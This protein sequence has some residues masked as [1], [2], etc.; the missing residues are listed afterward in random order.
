[1]SWPLHGTPGAFGGLETSCDYAGARFAV[2]PIP[3]DGTSTWLKG[4]DRG[5]AAM[6][7]ASANME[8]FDIE[9]GTE[10]WRSGILTAA[11]VGDAGDPESTVDAVAAAAGRFLDG[12]K[13]VLGLGGEHSVTAGLVRAHAERIPG[14]SVL[15]FDA[16]CDRRESYEGSPW[17]HACVMARVAEICPCVQ[18]GIRS[19]DVS[20]SA[21]LDSGRIFTASRI[22]GDSSF[23]SDVADLLTDDVYVTVD[24]D[25]LDPG[26]MPSTGTP[27]PGGMDWWQLLSVLRRVSRRR[28][29]VGCDIVELMPRDCDRAPDFLAARLAY[30]VMAYVLTG[31]EST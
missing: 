10:P 12:G 8:L 4:A 26:I 3:Y 25:V 11:P 18:V 27:E 9:T 7:A 24:L 6:L 14:L 16:H 29:I 1:M 19:M 15:Q 2:L 5:P 23:A 28:R 17:N 30:Q 21:L 22:A 13:F 31:K 20:E